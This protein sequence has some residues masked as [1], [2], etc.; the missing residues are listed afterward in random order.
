VVIL[1]FGWHFH[2]VGIPTSEIRQ[3][4]EYPAKSKF[5]NLDLIQILLE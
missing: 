5:L 4:E 1:K 2:H 3:D